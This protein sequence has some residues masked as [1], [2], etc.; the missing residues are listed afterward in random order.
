MTDVTLQRSLIDKIVAFLRNLG[1]AVKARNITEQTFLPG[2]KVSD[3]ALLVDESQLKYPGD[4]LHEAGHMAIVTHE[5]RLAG[6]VGQKAPEEMMAIAWSYAAAVHLGLEPSV[7][8]HSG[9]YHGWQETFIE[10]LNG[11]EFVGIT[12]LEEIGLTAGKSK[13]N[14][15]GVAPYPSMI[16][17]LL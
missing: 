15:Q 16:R 13:A 2:I 5:K 6:N 11:G 8:I 3:G 9:G 1:I 12:L 14:E 17:W 4:L 10:S 7:V